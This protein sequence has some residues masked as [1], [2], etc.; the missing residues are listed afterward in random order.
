MNIQSEIDRIE[1]N[2]ADTYSVLAEA[3][4]PMPASMDSDNL[5]GTAANIAAVLFNKAQSLTPAQQA[6]ARLNIGLSDDSTIP[7]GSITPEKTSFINVEGS[8]EEE[9]TLVP[10][11]TN[12]ADPTSSDWKTDTR[13]STSSGS[14][15]SYAGAIVTNAISAK[16][17][18]VIR[19]KG[20]KAGSG[21]TASAYFQMV[22]YDSAGNKLTT[23]G[24]LFEKDISATNS[25]VSQLVTVENGVTTYTLMLTGAAPGSQ[26]S[27]AANTASVRIGGVPVTTAEDIIITINE[28]I[29]YTEV[30]SGGKTYSLDPSIEVPSA[31]TINSKAKWFA[32]G[33][34]ITE[35]WTSEFDSS[36]SSGYKQ[37]LNTNESQRWVNI[38][39]AQY[40][41]V[42]TNYGVGGTGYLYSTNNAKA[43]VNTINFSNCDF[44]TL[45][46]GV[47]DWKYAV[48]IGTTE[49]IPQ[50]FVASAGQTAFVLSEITSPGEVYKNG[51]LLTQGTDYSISSST[52]TLST[53]AARHDIIDVYEQTPTMVGNMCYVIKKIIRDNPYCKIFVITPIN[54]RSLGYY[55]TDWGIGYSGTAANGL[56]L[57][58]IHDRLV[59]VCQY[60]GIEYIDMTYSSIVNRDN[61]LVVLPDNVHPSVKCHKAMA[62]EI[63]KRINFL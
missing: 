55:N 39:A 31:E 34:S 24:V 56:G 18:D 57:K 14:M 2:I 19:I 37:F 7:N 49:D 33:D 11:F 42:L 53:A 32:L 60:Y 61:I 48:E 8:G 41:Y 35:G 23:A 12:L 36:A 47:N 6:Q 58:D 27:Y 30:T 4:A 10:N 51:V 20:I 15:S 50:T 21:S 38:V 22:P 45:A 54:C 29:T 16:V 46:Y 3:G 9:T 59:S 5:A 44:V 25:G 28:P 26:N 40:G 17:G 43:L 63:S 52:L 1:Q 62:D 13:F